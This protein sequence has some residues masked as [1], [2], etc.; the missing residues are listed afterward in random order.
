MKIKA[1]KIIKAVIKYHTKNVVEQYYLDRLNICK[2]CPIY[3][4]G[5]CAPTKKGYNSITRT[6]VNGCGCVV[7]YKAELKDESCPLGKW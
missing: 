5:I 1:K 3:T 6:M 4:L 2:A 7:A